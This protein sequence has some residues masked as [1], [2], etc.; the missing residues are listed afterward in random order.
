MT[1]VLVPLGR[2]LLVPATAKILLLRMPHLV[3]E[4]IKVSGKI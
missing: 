1:D 2:G 4:I 3:L